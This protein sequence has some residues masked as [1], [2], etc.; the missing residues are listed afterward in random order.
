M[1]SQLSF[2]RQELAPV[3]S[4]APRTSTS[5]HHPS[6]PEKGQLLS[7]LAPCTDT[8]LSSTVAYPFYHGLLP[9]LIITPFP[10][11]L[12]KFNLNWPIPY[13][14]QTFCL[15]FIHHT[16]DGGSTHLWHLWSTPRLHGAI[17]QK[18][19]IFIKVT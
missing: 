3:R 17:S 4:V 13:I 12:P 1:L 9:C 10:N 11:G 18:A 7:C 8:S 15:W 2:S 16:N 14:H 19:I 5:W 6:D